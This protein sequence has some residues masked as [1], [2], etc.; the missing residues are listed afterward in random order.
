MK[1]EK[2]IQPHPATILQAKRAFPRPIGSEG[3]LAQGSAKPR[4][5]PHPATV[6]QA[7]SAFPLGD[8]TRPVHAATLDWRRAS[9]STT[10]SGTPKGYA[11]AQRMEQAQTPYQKLVASGREKYVEGAGE[12]PKEE[13]ERRRLIFEKQYET[14]PYEGKLSISSSLV[15]SHDVQGNEYNNMMEEDGTFVASSNHHPVLKSEKDV[16]P[17]LRTFKPP[18]SLSEVIFRQL[19]IKVRQGR[20]WNKVL[21]RSN[22][23]NDETKLVFGQIGWQSGKVYLPENDEFYAL[24]STPNGIAGIFLLRDHGKELGIRRIVSIRLKGGDGKNMFIQ[25]E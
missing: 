12:L 15:T 5:P 19:Q 1:N 22:V 7:K 17:R 18:L 11:V 4:L 6:V 8:A 20:A 3:R 14:T 10:R 16:D 25:F 23:V 21:K 9:H 13:A 24:L 2:R